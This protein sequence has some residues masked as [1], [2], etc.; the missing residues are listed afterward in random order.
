MV[1]AGDFEAVA[2][3]VPGGEAEFLASLDEAEEGVAGLL[4]GL[5][6]GSAGDLASGDAG[7]DVVLRAVGVERHF[8]PIEDDQEF[9][10]VGVDAGQ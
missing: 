6:S 2:E 5:G 3:V 10:L 7:A 4:S 8:G 9:G 1:G